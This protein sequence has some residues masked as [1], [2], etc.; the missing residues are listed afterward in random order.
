[1]PELP[2]VETIKRQLDQKV[3]GFVVK[4]IEVKNP[5]SFLGNPKR[6]SGLV[7]QGVSRRAKMIIISLSKPTSTHG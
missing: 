2:E 1:M 3:V 4:N 6:L 5:R 7:V